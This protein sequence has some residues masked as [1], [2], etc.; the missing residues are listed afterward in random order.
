MKRFFSLLVLLSIGSVM[1][2]G[3]SKNF[4]TDVLTKNYEKTLLPSTEEIKNNQ[5]QQIGKEAVIKTNKG[6]TINCLITGDNGTTV[7]YREI[8]DG[9]LTDN[10]AYVLRKNITEI[11]Y[12]EE[13]NQEASGNNSSS[14]NEIDVYFSQLEVPQAFKA[15]SFYHWKFLSFPF[16]QNSILQKKAVMRHVENCLKVGGDAVI[17]EPNLVNSTV[18]KYK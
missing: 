14:K 8:H 2:L 13:T 6:E 18:I 3:C 7:Y 12:K 11:Q 15:V 5:Q 16:S 9:L 10:K 1:L 4:Y 17:I